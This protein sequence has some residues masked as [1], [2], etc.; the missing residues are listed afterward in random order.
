MWA[1]Q[2]YF[3]SQQIKRADEY[4]KQRDDNADQIDVLQKYIQEYQ[5][6]SKS[7]EEQIK[8]AELAK[9]KEEPERVKDT[10]KVYESAF[11]FVNDYI[12]T[13]KGA[14]HIEQ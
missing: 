14:E 4:R 8:Q 12:N 7:L 1:Y 13:G 6:Y 9:F 11:D 3:N 5:A 2:V 10:P